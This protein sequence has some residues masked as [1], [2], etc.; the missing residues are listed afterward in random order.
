M[1]T[2]KRSDRAPKAILFR[3]LKGSPSLLLAGWPANRLSGMPSLFQ[4]EKT[5]GSPSGIISLNLGRFGLNMRGLVGGEL[6]YPLGIVAQ[7]QA[8]GLVVEPEGFQVGQG[9]SRCDHGVVGAK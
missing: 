2:I 5:G 4:A 3:A 9:L 6:K 7:K 1:S 8:F